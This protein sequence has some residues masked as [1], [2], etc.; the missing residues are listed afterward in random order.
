MKKSILFSIVFFSI[1]S[2]CNR[3]YAASPDWKLY[4]S[5]SGI[6][7]MYS[8]Q[9]CHDKFNDLHQEIVIFKLVNTTEVNY[10]IEWKMNFW[11]N[12]VCRNCNVNGKEFQMKV[13]VPAGET[14]A[15]E[16]YQGKHVRELTL[17]SK[18]LNYTDKSVLTKFELENIKVSVK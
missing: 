1:F 8:Y 11:Y 6:Q 15:G 13:D 12:G 16:C 7:I 5:V 3:S 10:Q 9:E 4:K 14:V 18:F 17:F 2:F